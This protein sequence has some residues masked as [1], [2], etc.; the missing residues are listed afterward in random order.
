MSP[1]SP[2]AGGKAA[3]QEEPAWP[4]FWCLATVPRR[5]LGQPAPGELLNRFARSRTGVAWARRNGFP[6]LPGALV[7]HGE[8]MGYEKAARL[9]DL[10]DRKENIDFFYRVAA[11]A[12]VVLDV[13]A[14]TGRIALP[15]AERGVH[16]CCVEPSPA[17]RREFCRK[18]AARPALWERIQLVAGD[19]RSFQ[20]A[21]VFP[22]AILS[23][24]FDHF[25][26]DEERVA[27]LENMGRHLVPGG[28]LVFDVFLGLM[29]DQ[30]LSPAG[31][32]HMEGQE[33][34]RLVGGRVVSPGRKEVQ[35]VYEVY[36]AGEL[37]ERIEER[38]QVGIID[39]PGVH[40]ALAA[41]GFK[42]GRQWAG[43]E[44]APYQAGDPLLIVEAI[45][46][47]PAA[48]GTG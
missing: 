13:G 36:A 31:K 43:Y 28:V 40:A 41:A 7:I 5:G 39:R 45:K 8:A 24:T 16:L 46:T 22:A 37:V 12:R 18:L 20:V 3:C 14:G 29:D 25:L 23:G 48:G 15:L 35:I 44:Q 11:R 26:D 2:P 47:G 10:F 19:A 4:S 32:A 9:Y 38:G 34:R 33:I 21:Q 6:R 1:H 42:V 27:S 17:M 30:P